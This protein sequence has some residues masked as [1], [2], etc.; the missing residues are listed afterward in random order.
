MNSRWGL[1][2]LLA[3]PSWRQH[4]TIRENKKAERVKSNSGWMEEFARF[5]LQD[6]VRVVKGCGVCPKPQT[7]RPLRDFINPIYRNIHCFN[8]CFYW[9]G[10][11]CSP[12]KERKKKTTIEWTKDLPLPLIVCSYHKESNTSKHTVTVC[13]SEWFAFI[14]QQYCSMVGSCCHSMITHSFWLWCL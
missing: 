14:L 6:L 9:V 13:A 8:L 3:I 2:I 5:D 1:Y 4:N 12:A 7:H 10:G 11:K